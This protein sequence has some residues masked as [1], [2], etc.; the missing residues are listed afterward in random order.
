MKKI[1]AI[2]L[3]CIMFFTSLPLSVFAEEL[4][5]IQSQGPQ[6]GFEKNPTPSP[7]EDFTFD[8]DSNI[9][10]SYNGS[11]EYVVIPSSFRYKGETLDVDCLWEYDYNGFIGN[12][13][14]KSVYIS[15]GISEIEGY[16][17]SYCTSLEQIFIPASVSHIGIDGR[18]AFEGCLNLN[19]VYIES[20]ESWLGITFG[21]SVSNPLSD[22]KAW[23]VTS[24]S[25][26]L[27]LNGE[28]VTDIVIP[29]SITTV[30]PYAFYSYDKL[31]S[32]VFHENVISVRNSA[33]SGC[34]G[35]TFVEFLGDTDVKNSGLN[36]CE[37]V[38]FICNRNSKPAEY[39]IENNIPIIFSDEYY[40][41]LSALKQGENSVYFNGEGI[42]ASGM[43]SV[44]IDF[45]FK[46][47]RTLSNKK[48]T[49]TFPLGSSL[50]DKSGIT[51]DNE[52]VEY[53]TTYRTVT[54]NIDPSKTK[55]RIRFTVKPKSD[56]KKSSAVATVEY[57]ENG[58]TTK[59]YIAT[60]YYNPP[61]LTLN[62]DNVTT[63]KTITVTGQTSP[64]KEVSI[65]IDNKHYCKVF[66]NKVGDYSATIELPKP[67]GTKVYVI[68]ATADTSD[69]KK[70]TVYANVTYNEHIPTVTQCT[71]EH[72]GQS[73]DLI[74]NSN[75]SLIYTFVP[76]NE[77]SVVIYVDDPGTTR[78]VVVN[79]TDT[80]GTTYSMDAKWNSDRN[81]FVANGYFNENDTSYV[82]RNLSVNMVASDEPVSFSDTQSFENRMDQFRE[83]TKDVAAPKDVII[84]ENTDTSLDAEIV[85]PSD[86]STNGGE[87]KTSRA[88]IEETTKENLPQDP[89][90]E[91]YI[92]LTDDE[93][94]TLWVK[95]S[96]DE[97]LWP[98]RSDVQQTINIFDPVNDSGISLVFD[99][100]M[101]FADH[102]KILE[103]APAANAISKSLSKILGP[104]GMMGTYNDYQELIDKV[105]NSNL[106]EAEKAR[107]LQSLNTSLGL[108]MAMGILE[109]AAGFVGGGMVDGKY[110]AVLKLLKLGTPTGIA[111]SCGLLALGCMS[112][113][114][115]NKLMDNANDMIDDSF[116]KFAAN[117]NQSGSGVN[118][119]S[120]ALNQPIPII[121]PSGYVY[122]NVT[123]ERLEGVTATAYY[124]PED[125]TDPNF[126]DNIPSDDN[127]GIYWDA[128]EY[129]QVNP[130][131]TDSEGRY[132]WDV[133]AGWWR[134]KYYKDGYETTWSE[135][136]PVPPPQTE[137]NIGMTPT[138]V[139][140]TH[141][142]QVVVIDPTCITG[143]YSRF[144]CECGHSY[145]G[146]ETQ[147]LG[148]DNVSYSGK[149]GTCSSTGWTAYEVCQRC[150]NSSYLALDKDPNHH[151]YLGGV[152][153][154]C[155]YSD[156]E[157]EPAVGDINGDGSINAVD[158][159]LLARIIAGTYKLDDEETEML[160]A[161][162]NG[163]SLINAVDSNLLKRIIAGSY[164]V[165]E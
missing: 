22:R 67:Q 99:G 88:R 6:I 71:L 75:K 116:R 134:V 154:D 31:E 17:F 1:I 12:E 101:A 107:L 32:V 119:S 141:D 140:H 47:E 85:F 80:R 66:A 163:D 144:T 130:L 111:M 96:A 58:E 149:P 2:I 37:N 124:I 160:V 109:Q 92:P 10:F 24:T 38:V 118:M 142:Y 93:G 61:K 59:E 145:I 51:I 14:V 113:W 68:S 26:D 64:N 8:P 69:G 48:I 82:P 79:S 54:I 98:S 13:K 57:T 162:I 95:H 102:Y 135:W 63:E 112:T 122:D 44:I 20:L 148:H 39:A 15:P 81:A 128:S 164:K 115:Q 87:E 76:Q 126:W 36:T 155:G 108:S 103:D 5:S 7:E 19:R 150:D 132:A 129:S 78:K 28:L 40:S 73:V 25:G 72:S 156:P 139:P 56:N 35:L 49:V 45:S 9:C 152:C 121:D 161:D 90:K 4:S 34:S 157:F 143:G 23:P 136:L 11:D 60:A 146:D 94:K 21:S 127:Y 74:G 46:E 52:P 33:F 151:T 77:Y 29:D 30:K 100:A 125:E 53:T 18:S 50:I 97:S 16:Y 65:Y 86:E 83:A 153:A 27:Y 104:L 105:N 70:K 42:S 137:V 106:P 159:N 131:M 133:P 117:A 84:H 110:A 114:A 138:T 55:G 3:C 62:A 123:N 147:A 41:E 165:S 89:A 91:G 120:L 158:S 43:L